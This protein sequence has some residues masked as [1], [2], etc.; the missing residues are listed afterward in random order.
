MPLSATE[1]AD[2]LWDG[3]SEI[4]NRNTLCV[5]PTINASDVKE[6]NAA[7]LDLRLGRWF[8]TMR[9]TRV[10]EIQVGDPRNEESISKEHYVRFNDYFAL[11][12][13]E[14]VIGITLEWLKFPYNLSG[15]V[16]G[17]SS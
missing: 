2:R 8:R 12:P 7:A 10:T 4:D 16:T 6:K 11:H 1:L 3:K 13:G 14:F 9:K 17:K 15:Y 5:V